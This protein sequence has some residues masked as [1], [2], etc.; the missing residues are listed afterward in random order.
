MSTKSTILMGD[1]F[2]LFTDASDGGDDAHFPPRV[3]LCLYG[4]VD[5]EATN[6]SVRVAIPIDVWE[7]IRRMGVVSLLDVHPDETNRRIIA[8]VQAENLIDDVR[9]G[10]AFARLSL[11]RLI[12]WKDGEPIDRQKLQAAI[13]DEYDRDYAARGALAKRVNALLGRLPDDELD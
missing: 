13:A 6:D 12:G 11:V 8:H 9:G 4:D 5:Y 10:S 3:H 7:A 2:H 1:G